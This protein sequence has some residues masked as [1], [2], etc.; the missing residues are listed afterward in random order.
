MEFSAAD[1]LSQVHRRVT[2]S[3]VGGNGPVLIRLDRRLAAPPPSLWAALTEASQLAQWFSEV[4]GDLHQGGRF[5]VTGNASGTILSCA[6]QQAISVTWGYGAQSG[7]VDLRITPDGT[8]ARL[9]LN[10]RFAPDETLKTYGPGALGVGWEWSLMELA[11]H[12]DGHRP[13]F[14]EAAFAATFEGQAFVRGSAEFWGQAAIADGAEA[15]D[16]GEKARL[17]AGFYLGD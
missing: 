1:H 4:T 5:A 9:T 7:Q 16:A 6:A 11:R 15:H 14:D 10:H 12:L 2:G 17:T 13:R 8:G 3:T